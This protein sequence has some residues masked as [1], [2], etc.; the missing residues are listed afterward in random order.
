MT[1]SKPVSRRQFLRS[2]GTLSGAS[3]LRILGP[4]LA[5]ITSAA[6]TAKQESAPFKVLTD[7]ETDDLAAI[8][9][10]LI[11]TTDTPG[12]TEAGVVY[13]FD[14]AFA[15]EMSGQLEVARAGLAEFNAA[16]QESHPGE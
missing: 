11:P 3:Y 7:L 4:G 8:A 15:A 9:A 16:L 5:A 14:N 12:A 13:F 1:D 10:R 6:C 2:A